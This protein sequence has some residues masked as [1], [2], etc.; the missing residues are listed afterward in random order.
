M[1][2]L[3]AW[4]LKFN[5]A[6]SQGHRK[7]QAQNCISLSLSLQ[8]T[9]ITLIWWGY[10]FSLFRTLQS[11]ICPS[12]DQT[13]QTNHLRYHSGGQ[14]VMGLSF[15][16][17]NLRTLNQRFACECH[18]TPIP[19]NRSENHSCLLLYIYLTKKKIMTLHWSIIMFPKFSAYSSFTWFPKSSHKFTNSFDSHHKFAVTITIVH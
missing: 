3:H 6:R 1:T 14:L 18:A 11:A 8:Y 10:N 17:Q 15:F 2:R 7:I 19:I 12:P 5:K 4:I 9:D 16:Y 13:K